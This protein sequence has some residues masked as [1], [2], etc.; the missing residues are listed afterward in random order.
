[1][2][3]I[4]FI[5]T[6]GKV[7][8]VL[9]KT[10]QEQGHVFSI[11]HTVFEGM[12]IAD[13]YRPD[14]IFVHTTVD[15]EK[16]Q[17]WL[18]QLLQCSI[19]KDI[20]ILHLISE[21]L[22]DSPT[23]SIKV[24]GGSSSIIKS[25]QM[26]G[27]L[28]LIE[29]ALGGATLAPPKPRGK[30]L[31]VDDEE[32]SRQLFACEL[33]HQGHE[34]TQANNGRE[35]LA[36]LQELAYDV[37]L[38]DIAMP[39]MDGFSALAH[40]RLDTKLNNLPIIMLTADDDAESVVKCIELGANDYIC[41]PFSFRVLH[42]RIEAALERK[43]I[44]AQKE[45]YVHRLEQTCRG[46]E[47]LLHVVLQEPFPSFP[48]LEIAHVRPQSCERV[49]VLM[50][51]TQGNALPH[52]KHMAEVFD[53]LVLRHGLVPVSHGPKSWVAI[54]GGGHPLI[55]PVSTTIRCGMKLLDAFDECLPCEI[56]RIGVDYGT[57]TLQGGYHNA[58]PLHI[59]GDTVSNAER[60][61]K[62]SDPGYITLSANAW[63]HVA[64]QY[65]CEAFSLLNQDGQENLAMYRVIEPTYFNS[66][67]P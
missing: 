11:A 53:A 5:D 27:V 31:L 15:T 66:Q 45:D 24:V 21:G 32:E 61:A 40:I 12:Y 23:L 43:Q 58:A 25:M 56:V 7:S 2:A 62:V 44:Q 17:E 8:E 49:A 48:S 16:G 51:R 18:A 63:T 35:A 38:L 19:T 1:M 50:A 22:A 52:H 64:R 36:R 26:D 57:V 54:G 9:G 30:V 13:Q 6:T 39:E 67:R 41:K 3:S 59:F 34:V 4:L 55:N 47:R 20:P 28:T 10:L 65:D 60:I 37:V 46:N 33:L 42:A 29:K 14:L